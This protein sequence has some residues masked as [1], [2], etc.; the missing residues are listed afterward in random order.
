MIRGSAGRS[1]SPSSFGHT[2][3]TGTSLWID[4]ETEAVMILL[5]HRRSP[6][7][8]LNVGRRRFH[9]LAADMIAHSS[10]GG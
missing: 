6:F 10:A 4:P 1:L 3:F 7:S 5:A 8:D 9:R 2:G